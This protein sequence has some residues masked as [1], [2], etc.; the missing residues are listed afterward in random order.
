MDVRLTEQLE[1]GTILIEGGCV[2]LTNKGSVIASIG[3]FYRQNLLP[4][5]R[6]LMGKYTDDLTDPFR[7]SKKALN[8]EC[9]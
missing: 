5:K 9:K 7:Y 4:K 8:Y 6:L 3:R 1:S 2:K